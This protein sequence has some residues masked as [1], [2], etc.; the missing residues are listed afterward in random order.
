MRLIL[1]LF[2][3]SLIISCNNGIKKP[4]VS[5]IQIDLQVYRFE[6][7]LFK[8]DSADALNAFQK[9]NQFYPNFSGIY[10]EQIL[11]CNPA[12][13]KDSLIQYL[14]GFTSSFHPVYD[15]S[16]K[17]FADFSDHENEVKSAMK[18]VHYYFPE[19]S[20]PQ[21]LITYIGPPD[22]FGDILLKDAWMIG[23]QQHLGRDA[24]IYQQPWLQETYPLYISYRFCP[25]YIPVNC[26]QSIVD[27]MYP[28]NKTEASLSVQ[29]IESG[30]RLYLLQQFLPDT[31]EY[32]L[33]GYSDKQLEDCYQHE[34]VIWNLF[35]QNNYLQSID[36]NIIQN[37]IQEGPRTQELG[38]AAPGK[39]GVFCG[40]QIVKK[41]MNEHSDCSLKTL[42]E[43]DAEKIMLEAKYKP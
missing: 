15:S 38:E 27:D 34:N 6:Q 3:F 4:D 5:N 12:W 26:M 25:E 31:K 18:Y 29:M 7:D 19:Y 32:L 28:N 37:Y 41:Y 8:A 40:W 9:A 16:A 11:N 33:I 42:M 22:G 30:K 14:G 21:K 20:L 39:I 17:L 35:I 2:L 1:C 23:L 36:K 24:S 43:T 10:L 13:S